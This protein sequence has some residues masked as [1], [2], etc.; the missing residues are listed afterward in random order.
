VNAPL[1]ELLRR[2]REAN[3]RVA[4]VSDVHSNALAYQAALRTA[5]ECGFDLLVILGDLLTYGFDAQKVID[6]THELV[7]SGKAIL[8]RGNHDQLYFD[9]FET[10]FANYDRLPDW[11]KECVNWTLKHIDVRAFREA[12][13]WRDQIEIGDILLAHANPYDYGDWTYLNTEADLSCAAKVL[14]SRGYRVGVFGHTHRSMLCCLDEP[15]SISRRDFCVHVSASEL[16]SSAGVIVNPGSVGQ[17]RNE[18]CTSTVLLLTC[19]P[20]GIDLELVRF[21]YDIKAHRD[22]ILREVS[23]SESAREKLLGFFLPSPG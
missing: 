21:D 20:R 7:A 19:G 16:A 13:P 5:T 18:T 14:L 4:V 2:P 6:Y 15:E 10:D 23:L 12:H 11:L 8:I 17:P 9:L 1:D 22:T 3:L